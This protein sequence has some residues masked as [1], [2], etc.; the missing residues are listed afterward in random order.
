MG[1]ERYFF[2]YAVLRT[3]R[4]IDFPAHAT[5]HAA[6]QLQRQAR[7]GHVPALTLGGVCP[8]RPSDNVCVLLLPKIQGSDEITEGDSQH[9]RAGAP[10]DRRGVQSNENSSPSCNQKFFVL[11]SI[12]RYQDDGPDNDF[13]DEPNIRANISSDGANGDDPTETVSRNVEDVEGLANNLEESV[14]LNK[15]S[16]PGK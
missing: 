9:G 3:G 1:I 13:E 8:A 4:G 7:E 6:L 5:I 10:S 11:N 12:F 16:A 15:Q 2:N 14:K